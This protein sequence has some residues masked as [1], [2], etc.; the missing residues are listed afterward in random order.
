[1]KEYKKMTPADLEELQ[2]SFFG[3]NQV[4]KHA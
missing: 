2:V 3:A 1:M 4:I